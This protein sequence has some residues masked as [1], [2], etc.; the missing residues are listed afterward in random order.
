MKIDLLKSSRIR[1]VAAAFLIFFMPLFCR[2][3]EE[4]VSVTGE[5]SKKLARH[6][7]RDKNGAL[8]QLERMNLRTYQIFHYPLVEKENQKPYDV[9]GDL[10]LEPFEMRQYLA[11]KVSGRLK[12]VCKEYEEKKKAEERRRK[13]RLRKI[14]EEN[15]VLRW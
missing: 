5:T 1:S 7:D 2:A 8:D 6:F 9:D 11:D 14:E 4:G 3:G 12:D 15:A 10:M 13:E